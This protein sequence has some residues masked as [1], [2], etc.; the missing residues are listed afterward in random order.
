VLVQLDNWAKTD[1]PGD[2]GKWKFNIKVMLRPDGIEG[3]VSGNGEDV[4]DTWIV[5][6]F[7]LDLIVMTREKCLKTSRS[8]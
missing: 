3:R 7:I 5:P 4:Y 6:R 2:A 1:Y 8:S